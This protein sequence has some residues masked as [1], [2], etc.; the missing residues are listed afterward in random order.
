MAFRV[1]LL[2]MLL[3]L[4]G[5]RSGYEPADAGQD[6]GAGDSGAADAETD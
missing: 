5:C 4:V 6:L 1:G 2:M 3:A